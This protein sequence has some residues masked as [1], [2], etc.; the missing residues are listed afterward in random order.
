MPIPNELLTYE[1]EKRGW[2]ELRL[3]TSLKMPVSERTIKRAE[4]GT[5]KTYPE[6]KD[7]LAEL[8][9]PEIFKKNRKEAW[10]QLGF[11]DEGKIPFSPLAHSQNP[12]FTSPKDLLPQIPP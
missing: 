11:V 5:A 8:L 9:K 7:Q 12:I 6:I 3:A 4:Q 10:R 1:R 2:S